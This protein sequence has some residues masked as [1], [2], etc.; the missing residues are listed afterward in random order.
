MT[1]IGNAGNGQSIV[2]VCSPGSGPIFELGLASD[3]ELENGP[4]E[5]FSRR[6]HSAFA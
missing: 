2:V 5:I 3:E 6:D 1:D 4:E